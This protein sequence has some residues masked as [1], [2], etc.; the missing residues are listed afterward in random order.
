MRAMMYGRPTPR[1]AIAPR[2]TSGSFHSSG[3]SRPESQ[4]PI[5]NISEIATKNTRPLSRRF[6][7]KCPPPG[8]SHARTQTSHL[9]LI[10]SLNSTLAHDQP[11]GGTSKRNG[12]ER[13]RRVFERHHARVLETPRDRGR[14]RRKNENAPRAARG[15]RRGEEHGQRHGGRGGHV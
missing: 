7:M 3:N 4:S 1:S 12:G 2:N 11:G 8:I 14:Q 15:Q 5:T 6:W 10:R 13:A 9:L